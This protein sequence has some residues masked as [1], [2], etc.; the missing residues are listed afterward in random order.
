M[1]EDTSSASM[2]P[3]EDKVVYRDETRIRVLR[4]RLREWPTGAP[5]A[6]V[7]RDDGEN[8]YIPLTEIVRVET[9]GRRAHAGRP[10]APQTLVAGMS[11]RT[12][13]PEYRD[14][15]IAL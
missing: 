12:R 4:G 10:A 5:F 14:I 2:T 6:V 13:E 3:D 8:I 9:Y 7:Q 11:E 1:T 15:S